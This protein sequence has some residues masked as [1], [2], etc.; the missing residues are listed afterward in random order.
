MN[1]VKKVFLSSAYCLKEERDLAALAIVKKGHLPV[2]LEWIV[3]EDIKI[4]RVI[5]RKL[6]KVDIGLF[7]IGSRYGDIDKETGPIW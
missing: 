2:N 7:I 4:S 3:S 5:E 1:K 6:K